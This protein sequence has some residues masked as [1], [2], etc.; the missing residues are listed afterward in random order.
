MFEQFYVI[1]KIIINQTNKQTNKITLVFTHTE[2]KWQLG[3]I[4]QDM[5]G[6]S[7]TKD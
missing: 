6:L 5:V 7:L 3:D 2:V 1:L 4:I